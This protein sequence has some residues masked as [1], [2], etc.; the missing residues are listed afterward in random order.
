MFNLPAEDLFFKWEAAN[1]NS[2][3]AFTLAAAHDLKAR[4]Q[5]EK[6]RVAESQRRARANLAGALRSAPRG[7]GAGIL[8]IGARYGAGGVGMPVKTELGRGPEKGERRKGLVAGPSRVKY[9]GPQ[10]SE[11]ARRGRACKCFRVLAMMST[12]TMQTGTCTRK[13]PSGVKVRAVN[14]LLRCTL[15]I[16][17]SFGRSH[18][19]IR[20]DCQESLQY[21]RLQ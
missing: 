7:G 18:R 9:E 12:Y 5:R 16:W 13:L 4:I 6:E 21:R 11:E 20:G 17:I 10:M 19:G 3:A 14:L 2:K 15:N 8:N 1:F